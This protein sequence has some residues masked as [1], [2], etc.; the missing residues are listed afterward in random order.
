MKEYS[1]KE[2]PM[3]ESWRKVLAEDIDSL[4]FRSIYREVLKRYEK[5][6][7]YPKFQDIFR[8]FN[9]TDI[10]DIKVLILG[11]DP[12]HGDKQANG[13]SFSVNEGISLPPSLRNIYKELYSD[14]G[15][16]NGDNGSLE[17]WAK[18]GVFLLNAG[19]TVR[20][21]HA[22]SHK[23]I[24]WERFTDS[25]IEKVDKEDRPIV[26]ILWGKYAQKKESLIK[27][28][29]HLIIK[30]P[31][32]SPLSSYRGFFGSKPFSKCNEFLTSHGVEA[33]DWEIK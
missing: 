1:F 13:L 12:Y 22:N 21:N 27:G 29:N 8:A 23:D 24:N 20:R 10:K 28:K 17:T 4:Y 19:L 32:P 31:H 14:L 25:V 18:Q 30:S 9:E 16:D 6:T 7:V 3:C 26:F 5:E 2:F 11:Q 15:I 33:I